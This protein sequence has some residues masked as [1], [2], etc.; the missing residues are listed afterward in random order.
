MSTAATV[1]L[2]IDAAAGMVTAAP[3]LVRLMPVPVPFLSRSVKV[4]APATLLSDRAVPVV[5]VTLVWVTSTPVSPPVPLRAVLAPVEMVTPM[6][7]ALVARL[8]GVLHGGGPGADRRPGDG[9]GGR[10]DPHHRIEA[11][12][13]DPLA[14]QPAAL[15]QGDP[16]GVGAVVEEDPLTGVGADGGDR[17]G[18]GVERRRQPAGLGAGGTVVD[19]PD[20]RARHGDGH[21]RRGAADAGRW[22]AVVAHR[23]GEGD[24]APG[25][26]RRRVELEGAR[27]VVEVGDRAAR[28]GGG[29]HRAHRQRGARL[30]VGRSRQ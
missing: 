2:A 29:A 4:R 22:S 15:V 9:A 3:T 14:D 7:R 23:V 27:G 25:E 5:V 6:T 11:G 26:P 21:R 13:G 10:G 17:F 12:S 16:G 19:E 1:V 20:D 24:V 28:R 18:K 8:D 30:D